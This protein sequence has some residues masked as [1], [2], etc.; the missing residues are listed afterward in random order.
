MWRDRGVVKELIGRAAAAGY[1]TLVLTVD[2]AVHGRRERDVRRGF[3][4]PPK[5][6]L[7]TLVD[8]ALHPGWT[9]NF[10]RGRT[11]PLRQRRRQH[12]RRRVRRGV[13]RRVH[14]GATRPECL[15]G[16]TSTGS[17]RS[18]TVRSSSRESR[19]STTRDSPPTRARPRSHCRTTA[20]AS[21]TPRR[22][23]SISSRR[24]PTPSAI[25]SRSSA[26]AASGA[27]ATS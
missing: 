24:L 19:P 27:A 20:G 16:A 3:T 26:T 1:E 18:G 11:D 9:W 2:L 21:S 15:V 4:L 13:A 5:L 25:A 10:V 14:R 8:G 6:G 22:C 17:A 7:G 12:G 23:R